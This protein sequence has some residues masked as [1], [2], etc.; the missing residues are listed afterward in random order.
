MKPPIPIYLAVEDDLS[1]WV[2]RRLLFERPVEYFVSAVF[3][4]GGFG[5]LKKQAPAFNNMAKACPVLLLTDLDQRPCAPELLQEW[6]AQPKH[7]DFLLRVAVR[8]IEAWLLASDD[9]LRKFIGT[10]RRYNID[11]PESLFDPKAELLKLAITSPRR[12]IR[13]ALVRRDQYGNLRQGP[14]YNSTLAEFVH[15]EWMPDTAA[16]KCSSLSRTIRALSSLESS[17]KN[18]GT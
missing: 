10:R 8:E 6:L 14:A 3:K 18:R 11:D 9:A 7:S 13:E 15:R 17:W 5:Y 2:L 16:I 12:D 4:K 1:E